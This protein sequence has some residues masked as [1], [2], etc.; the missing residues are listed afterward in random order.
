MIPW[1]P[2]GMLVFGLTVIFIF[3]RLHGNGYDF[4]VRIARCKDKLE[5]RK[6]DRTYMEISGVYHDHFRDWNADHAGSEGDSKDHEQRFMAGWSSQWHL[7]KK[8]NKQADPA[9]S[10]SNDIDLGVTDNI[11]QWIWMTNIWHDDG[12]CGPGHL[13]QYRRRL[14][15]T[16]ASD[17]TSTWE[18]MYVHKFPGVITHSSLSKRIIS[19]PP[20]GDVQGTDGISSTEQTSRESIRLAIVYKVAREE[21]VI[22]HSRVYHFGIFQGISELGE[23]KSKSTETETCHTHEPFLNFDYTLPGSMSIKDFTLEHDTIIYS[24]LGDTT[25]FRS[26]KLPRLEP[27]STSF[28]HPYVLPSGEPGTALEQK[29]IFHTEKVSLSKYHPTAKVRSA[30]GSSFHMPVADRICSLEIKQ[31]S[32]AE[33]NGNQEVQHS[34]QTLNKKS[35][36][37]G[38]RTLSS[39]F[40]SQWSETRIDIGSTYSMDTDYGVVSDAGDIMALKTTRNGVLILKRNIEKS[41][42]LHENG[43]WQLSMVMDDTQYNPLTGVIAKREVLAMKVVRVPMQFSE[44]MDSAKNKGKDETAQDPDEQDKKD[45]SVSPS[46]HVPENQVAEIHNI[47]GMIAVVA[48]FVISEAR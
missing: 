23:C 43:P 42:S 16:L 34:Q 37:A 24:R 30:D 18:L 48:A 13:R 6:P 3:I 11:Q 14:D 12:D 10:A 27:G 20:L 4:P 32:L 1:R 39:I 5:F 47:L 7:G 26:L 19:E 38:Y 21:S 41:T 45:E 33:S 9:I 40:R 8:K 44:E 29:E 2:L 36:A 25:A 46:A 31:G 35:G 17:N 15:H 22:Y 28:Q